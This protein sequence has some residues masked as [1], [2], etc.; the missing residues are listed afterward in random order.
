M[1]S[2]MAGH[3][4]DVITGSGQGR[5]QPPADETGRVGDNYPGAVI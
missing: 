1:I 2:G 4:S 3:G 5:A